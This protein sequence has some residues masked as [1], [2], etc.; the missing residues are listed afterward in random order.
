MNP[1]RAAAGFFI[2]LGEPDTQRRVREALHGNAEATPATAPAARDLPS[3]LPAGR[4]RDTTLLSRIED[5]GLNASAPPQQRW[6]DGWLLRFSPG[7]AKRARCIH[8]V[9]DGRLALPE[10]LA[11]AA[12]VYREAG[13]PLI[14]RVTPFSRP[15]ALDAELQAIGLP[16]FDDTRVMVSALP[17]TPVEAP[18]LPRGYTL[19]A[20]GHA[21]FAQTVGRMRG[22]PLA[23]RQAH[24]QRLELAPVPFRAYAIRRD[25]DAQPV[26]CGQFATE[27]ELVGLYDV[28]TD[29]A[30][31]GQGLARLLCAHLLAA[32]HAAGARTAY[33]Q[34]DAGNAAARRVYHALGFA[35]AYRY[36]YRGAP[37]G[38]G[39][40]PAP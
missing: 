2:P 7:K 13:L 5:A 22:S 8:P 26:A 19:Q 29:P 18:P 1:P 38:A 21:A 25:D 16:A 11:L 4:T 10:K 32:A 35:D 9:A 14:V 17:A 27:A 37:E 28:Y 15:H 20:L 6:F 34:V 30:L 24:A 36:H 39:P 33:L 31:R 23:Q 12:A 3:A 40:T